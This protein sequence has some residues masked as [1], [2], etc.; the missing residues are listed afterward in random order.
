M[1]GTTRLNISES[2]G[3]ATV[4]WQIQGAGDFNGDG[5]T[6][7]VWRNSASGQNAVWFLDGTSLSGV[8]LL[9][10]VGGTNW[11]IQGVGDFNGDQQ[12]DLVWRDYATGDNVVWL[13]NGTAFAGSA[14]LANVADLNWQIQGVGD[15]SGDGLPDLFWRNV[16]NGQNVIWAMSGTSLASVYYLEAVTD[17]NWRATAPLSGFAA[18]TPID[19]AGNA[20]D[21]A[22]NIG[23]LNGYGVYHD[24]VSNSDSDFYTFSLGQRGRVNLKLYGT[25]EAT[26]LGNPNRNFTLYP[27][28]NKGLSLSPILDSGTYV[29][30]VY[31]GNLNPD[32]YWLELSVASISMPTPP[33][34]LSLAA[35]G[36]SGISQTDR[37]T[38]ITTPVVTGLAEANTKVL[39]FNGA[40]KL[41]EALADGTGRWQ[42]T[43]SL[44]LAPGTYNLTAQALNA[45]GDASANSVALTIVIDTQTVTPILLTPEFAPGNAAILRGSAEAGALVQVF[46]GT[47]LLGI[48]TATATGSWQL[49]TPS[50]ALGNY[51]FSAIAT[52]IA[53]NVSPQSLVTSWAIAAS[54]LA[55]PQGLRLTAATDSGQ[56][57]T[58]SITNNLS[59]TIAGTATVGTTVRLF[60]NQQFLGQAP[61]DANGAWSLVLTSPLPSGTY[62]LTAIATNASGSSPATALTVT[63]DP[64]V[65]TALVNVLAEGGTTP[66]AL[67]NG[68]VLETGMR[69]VGQVDGTLSVIASLKYKLGTNPEVAIAVSP[70]GLF[71]QL[72]D[73]TGVVGSQTLVLL[74][75]DQAGNA[76]PDQSYTVTVNP[77]PANGLVLLA[78]LTQDTGSDV[79]DGWTSTPGVSGRVLSAQSAVTGLWAG[80]RAF[81]RRRCKICRRR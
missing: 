6:D 36:D 47:Q 37:V 35:A 46:E 45:T 52:D 22:F 67:T 70:E 53:G 48:A 28:G 51:D 26:L 62:A 8:T 74:A 42:I 44:V 71:N 69:L 29:V 64:L 31:S 63:I 13:M 55:A 80:L 4:P 76:L 73:L 40:T 16:D 11:Q 19:V 49:T 21:T 34:S 81:P 72:L 77:L 56:S 7:L 33:T 59:P 50:L 10:E 38:K 15:L 43:S 54:V 32:Q 18:P 25:A 24:T 79:T 5:K 39:L 58:D 30:Q 68:A 17:L 66:V 60:R 23:P 41:G 3:T 1:D 14:F 65:P 57:Q 12:S 78:Q 2:V 61:T 75:T 20:P 9:P 27:D